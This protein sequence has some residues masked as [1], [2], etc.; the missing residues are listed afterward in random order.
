ML[1]GRVKEKRE[2]RVGIP[3]EGLTTGGQAATM[4]SQHRSYHIEYC[5]LTVREER[6]HLNKFE[7]LNRVSNASEQHPCT[8]HETLGHAAGFS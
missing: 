4:D 7:D 2:K 6:L 3:Q 5:R 8:T 1:D